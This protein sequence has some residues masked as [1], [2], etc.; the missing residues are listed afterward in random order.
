MGFLKKLF[1]GGKPKPYVDKDGI[2]FHVRCDNCQSVVRLRIDKKH[3]LNDENGQFV[4]YKTIVDSK[5]FRQMK[6]V[7][8]FDSN[9]QVTNTDIQGGHHISE[10]E[11][12][13]ATTPAVS[14]PPEEAS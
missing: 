10:E 3:E 13:R 5:C 1:G 12:K 7:V 2:Y 4:W 11:Y 8:H 14:N 6:T 9:Y